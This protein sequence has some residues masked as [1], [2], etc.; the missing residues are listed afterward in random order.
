LSRGQ[1][2]KHSQ[3]ILNPLEAKEDFGGKRVMKV[4]VELPQLVENSGMV[5]VQL[6]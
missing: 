4:L 3:L 6:T 5:A 1:N 2:K